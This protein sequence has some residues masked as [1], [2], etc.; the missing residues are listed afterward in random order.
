MNRV[1]LP[2]S[3]VDVLEMFGRVDESLKCVEKNTRTLGYQCTTYHKGFFGIISLDFLSTATP[4]LIG[5]L[6]A[7]IAETGD[8]TNFELEK[9]QRFTLPLPWVY[10][11]SNMVVE[12]SLF[13]GVWMESDL[14]N[15]IFH[16]QVGWLED[17]RRL[18][19]PTRGPSARRNWVTSPVGSRWGPGATLRKHGILHWAGR[20]T[21]FIMM[22]SSYTWKRH[23]CNHP[24]RHSASGNI[25]TYHF[26][27]WYQ[28]SWT[29][30]WHQG[31]KPVCETCLAVCC[32]STSPFQWHLAGGLLPLLL[33]WS[34]G[35]SHISW[36]VLE[37]ETR[38]HWGKPAIWVRI[39]RGILGAAE[40]SFLSYLGHNWGLSPF[41]AVVFAADG[42]EGSDRKFHPAA[43]SGTCAQAAPSC[44]APM[45]MIQ[46][47]GNFPLSDTVLQKSAMILVQWTKNSWDSWVL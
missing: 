16:W 34:P 5:R 30:M 29:S 18:K 4:S 41:L 38:Y 45:A 21:K 37:P 28:F 19:L 42:F 15:M 44:W 9:F 46:N 6:Q 35:R 24:S 3:K 43:G 26:G 17:N 36:D 22:Y 25:S 31:S 2:D 12:K 33:G 47:R 40:D 32:S 23:H 11:Q 27:A 1:W 7:D 14:V 13:L 39:E 20:R 8:P 10:P